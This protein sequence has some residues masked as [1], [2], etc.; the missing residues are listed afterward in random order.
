MG[1]QTARSRA[2]TI[3]QTQAPG[4]QSVEGL[5][6][7]SSGVCP[8]RPET[9]YPSTITERISERGHI[10]EAGLYGGL[11]GSDNASTEA[12]PSSP[13]ARRFA[14][15]NGLARP[16]TGAPPPLIF[17]LKNTPIESTIRSSK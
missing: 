14:R 13:L 5:S 6:S 12:G 9:A 11:T 16:L 17:V 4:E 15:E 2:R 1:S 3:S 7:T 10:P 8:L